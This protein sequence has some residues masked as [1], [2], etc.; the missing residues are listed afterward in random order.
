V[1][2]RLSGFENR[3]FATDD[4]T[5]PVLCYPEINTIAEP[6]P[7]GWVRLAERWADAASRDLIARRY[8][9]A[10]EREEYRLRAPRGRRHWLMG[11]IAAKDAVRRWLW[12]RGAAPLFPVEVTIE[13]DGHGQPIVNV[14]GPFKLCV[15]IAHSGDL[16]VAIADEQEVGIDVEMIELRNPGLEMVALSAPERALL[17]RV[18]S[19]G[20]DFE[21]ARSEAFTR[22][23]AAKEAVSKAE[24]TGLGGRPTAFAV[25]AVHGDCLR[26]LCQSEPALPTREYTV[27]T[28]VIDGPVLAGGARAQYVVAW[29]HAKPVPRA[30]NFDGIATPTALSRPAHAATSI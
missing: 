24:G 19:S 2:A 6:E 1:W 9:G 17:D 4:V 13:N 5:W 22:F 21:R 8:L 12:A 29:T 30:S 28:R 27:D 7:G 15:S 16:A 11:R 18:V 23:W 14:S 26:V 3:R 25:A 10:S 20:S